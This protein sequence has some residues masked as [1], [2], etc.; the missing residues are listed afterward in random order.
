MDIEKIFPKGSQPVAQVDNGGL[1]PLIVFVLVAALI[2]YAS[3]RPEPGPGPGP[4]PEPTPAEVTHLLTIGGPASVVQS[5]KVTAAC[6]KL[7]LEY[8][9]VR[10]GSNADQL[11]NPF[12]VLRDAANGADNVAVA[13][14]RGEPFVMP[15][16]STA[17]EFVVYIEGL[18]Q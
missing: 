8:R 14:G 5:T 2:V 3:R 17:D 6:K 13:G 12:P 4:G 1:S 15:I 11:G 16:P 9:N 18:K 7:A 10:S